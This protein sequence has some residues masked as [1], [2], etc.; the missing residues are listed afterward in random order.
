MTL[1]QKIRELRESKGMFQRQLASILEVGDGFL[2]KVETDQKALKRQ[3]LKT[4]S[5]TFDC[6]FSELEALWIGSKVYDIVKDE[7]EGMNALKVAEQQ[8]QYEKQIK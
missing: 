7:K 3:H 6:S 2:S 5:E 1:G 4:I 8:M